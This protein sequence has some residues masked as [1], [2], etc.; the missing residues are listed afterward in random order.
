MSIAIFILVRDN[1]PIRILYNEHISLRRK[2]KR[3][4]S[5]SQ[6]YG[7]T[8]LLHIDP[9]CMDNIWLRVWNFYST[10]RSYFRFL[11]SSCRANF[12]V[13]FF[14]FSF[15]SV[16]IFFL[17]RTFLYSNISSDIGTLCS[18]SPIICFVQCT[19]LWY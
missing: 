18:S 5:L 4:L 2:V 1:R 6:L 3:I 9:I 17:F 13:L 16:L 15:V 19:F 10:I 8:L 12:F 14:C 7:G 11:W